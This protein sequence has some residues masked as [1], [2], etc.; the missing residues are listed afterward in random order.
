MTVND[1]LASGGDGFG[2]FKEGTNRIKGPIELDTLTQY[3]Q[4][5]EGAIKAPALERIEL[6]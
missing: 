1:I 4:S 6:Q 5:Y 3:I 2:V